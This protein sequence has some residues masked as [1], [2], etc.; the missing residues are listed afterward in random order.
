MTAAPEPTPIR[1]AE[2]S[3]LQEILT[4]IVSAERDVL[5]VPS[6]NS[7][8]ERVLAGA[9]AI[10]GVELVHS[11]KQ[12]DGIQAWLP[13]LRESVA[14]LGQSVM[15][16]PVEP[17]DEKLTRDLEEAYATVKRMA[18]ENN[19]LLE[20]QTGLQHEIERLK[21]EVAEARGVR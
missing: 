6:T 9:L 5:R 16:A 2:P 1:D 15:P 20:I 8:R 4:Q 19:R 18:G 17:P 11:E 10:M 14:A 21:D 3:L 7:D 13:R 12:L